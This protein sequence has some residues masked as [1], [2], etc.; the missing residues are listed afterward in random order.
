LLD[1]LVAVL[2]KEGMAGLDAAIAEFTEMQGAFSGVVALYGDD[3]ATLRLQ[4]VGGK[5]TGTFSQNSTDKD[6]MTTTTQTMNIPVQG[7]V[8]M[9]SGSIEVTGKGKMTTITKLNPSALKGLSREALKGLQ[10]TT[11]TVTDSVWLFRGSYYGKGYKGTA[12]QPWSVSR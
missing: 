11:T 12:A 5:V 2:Q 3:Q 6:S 4:V 8:D 10:T 1:R 9:V 7:T